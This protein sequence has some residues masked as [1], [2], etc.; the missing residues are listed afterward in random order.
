MINV[1]TTIFNKLSE[2]T[3]VFVYQNR[4][5][6]LES[7]PCVVFS[8]ESNIPMYVLEDDIGYQNMVVKVDIYA[9]LDTDGEGVLSL[10]ESKMRELG[11]LL[12]FNSEIPDPN[13]PD[14]PFHL[15]TQFSF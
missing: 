6:V 2:M 11:Y 9:E 7:F 8:I 3:G 5:E 12:T 14:A 13:D 15:S 4:P 10:A 1:R